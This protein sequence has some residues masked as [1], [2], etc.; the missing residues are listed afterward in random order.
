M[1]M[2]G[3]ASRA[4]GHQGQAARSIRMINIMMAMKEVA[5]CLVRASGRWLD[6]HV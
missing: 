3:V 6:V 2:K 4:S 1:A 5:S